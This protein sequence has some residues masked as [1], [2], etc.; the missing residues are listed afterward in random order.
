MEKAQITISGKEYGFRL[1]LE[2]WK[3]LKEVAQI[4][5]NNLQQKI[6]EDMA[7]V[8]SFLVFYGL[9]PEDRKTTTQQEIDESI[10][11]AIVKQITDIVQAGL[12]PTDKDDDP[13]N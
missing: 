2:S 8:V 5:P 3:K 1:T 13:K 4:T 12:S 7:G 10:D 6:E 11:L 9:S